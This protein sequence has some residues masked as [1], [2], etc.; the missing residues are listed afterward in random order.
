M[1]HAEGFKPVYCTSQDE[2]FSIDRFSILLSISP[3]KQ[4]TLFLMQ[5]L[6]GQILILH[7]MIQQSS[8]QLQKRKMMKNYGAVILFLF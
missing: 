2:L 4:Q 3:K 5:L 1:L 8:Q 7:S 6:M